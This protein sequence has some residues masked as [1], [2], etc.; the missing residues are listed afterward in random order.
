MHRQIIDPVI[1]HHSSICSSRRCCSSAD[2]VN[3]NAGVRKSLFSPVA[4]PTAGMCTSRPA[5]VPKPK[6]SA[7]EA[8]LDEPAEATAVAAAITADDSPVGAATQR[9]KRS[10][11]GAGLARLVQLER[12]GSPSVAPEAAG[13]DLQPGRAHAAPTR[14]SM[15]QVMKAQQP[16]LQA[17]APLLQRPPPPSP[18]PQP[19]HQQ[20]DHEHRLEQLAAAAMEAAA[21]A[22][23]GE[24]PG[25]DSEPDE[26][27]GQRRRSL[28]AS[29]VRAAPAAPKQPAGGRQR[30]SLRAY[31]APEPE[32]EPSAVD[33][34]TVEAPSTEA[35]SASG[36]S[37]CGG[38]GGG[39]TGTM[40]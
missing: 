4:P 14:T 33:A 13:R 23:V 18:Q 29:T 15:R 10:T 17:A 21:A 6:R 36:E 7:E 34:G 38:R 30:R 40:L 19:Q 24:Q 39:G 11:A 25:S 31:P 9:S 8:Q 12:D 22:A 2:A 5:R 1:D 3:D 16:Q 26:T 20:Q 32:P 37:V 27:A 28:R 35:D